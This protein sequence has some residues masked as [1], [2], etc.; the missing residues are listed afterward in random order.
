[1]KTSVSPYPPFFPPVKLYVENFHVYS[2]FIFVPQF[3]F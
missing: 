1:M 3:D 2:S